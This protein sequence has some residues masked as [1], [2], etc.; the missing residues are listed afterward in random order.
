MFIGEYKVQLGEKNRVLIPK[1]LRDEIKN[2]I[3]ITRGY[4]KTLLLVDELRWEMLVKEINKK[5]LLMLNVRDTKRFILG[6]AFEVE[7]D[8]QGRFVI[9]DE[10]VTFAELK[11]KIVFLGVGEWIEIWNEEKW[12]K[13]LSILS[14]QVSDLVEKISL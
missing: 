10:L 13:K 5:P 1:K 3:Y 9:P 12:M 4:E 6:G 14:N 8:L 11:N 2:K 7:L